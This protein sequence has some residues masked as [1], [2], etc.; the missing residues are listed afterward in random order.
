MPQTPATRAQKALDLANR[1]VEK[2][3]RVLN[4][5]G[6]A[7]D[8]ATEKANAARAKFETARTAYL[9]AVSERD[10]AATHPALPGNAP[11]PQ[12]DPQTAPI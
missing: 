2:T 11:E 1:D 5:T 3:E 9:S 6:E 10:H 4:Q 7:L 8:K 12:D